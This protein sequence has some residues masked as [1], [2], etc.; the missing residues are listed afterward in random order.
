MSEET[1]STDRLPDLGA[2]LTLQPA[3]ATPEHDARRT[4][5]DRP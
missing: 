4:E 3:A 1:F 5:K 2:L